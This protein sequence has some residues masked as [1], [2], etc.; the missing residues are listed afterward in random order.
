MARP[1]KI[2]APDCTLAEYIA[3]H[4]SAKFDESVFL[5]HV[6]HPD[7]PEDDG[8]TITIMQDRYGVGFRLSRGPL[9]CIY[10]DGTQVS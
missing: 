10:S 4:E 2:E 9:S 1:K 5:V 6:W 8:A 3:A 7:A